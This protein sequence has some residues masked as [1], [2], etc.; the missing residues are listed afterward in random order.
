MMY[1][2]KHVESY[3][4]LLRQCSGDSTA[5]TPAMRKQTQFLE[6]KDANRVFRVDRSLV[7]HGDR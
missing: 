4:V 2:E 3:S 1:R 6:A 7:Q 5:V